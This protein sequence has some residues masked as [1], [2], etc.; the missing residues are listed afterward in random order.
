MRFDEKNYSTISM[1]ITLVFQENFIEK[2]Y[3]RRVE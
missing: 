3:A 2:L 1:L